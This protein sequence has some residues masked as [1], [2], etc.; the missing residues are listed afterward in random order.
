MLL[1]GARTVVAAPDGRRWQLGQADGRC[2]R[3]GLGD[4]LAGYAA[5]CGARALATLGAGGAGEGMERAGDLGPCL[6]PLLA[7]AALDHA[8]AGLLAAAHHGRGVTP[9]DV[10]RMLKDGEIRTFRNDAMF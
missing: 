8:S 1:K 3:T 10:A 7:A 5:G 6:A 4:V 2:A 9:M